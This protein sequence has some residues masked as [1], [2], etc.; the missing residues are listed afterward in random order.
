MLLAVGL[1]L[2]LMSLGG[3]A[4]VLYGGTWGALA[5]VVFFAGALLVLMFLLFSSSDKN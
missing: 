4:L 3:Y 1:Y 2:L 5:Q